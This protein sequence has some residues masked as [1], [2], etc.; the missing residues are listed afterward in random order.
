M[1]L[2]LFYFERNTRCEPQKCHDVKTVDKYNNILFLVD[3]LKISKKLFYDNPKLMLF[4][5]SY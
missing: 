2:K 1:L 4:C 3:K 5:K